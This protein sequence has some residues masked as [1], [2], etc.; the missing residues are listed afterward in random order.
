MKVSVLRIGII[1][2]LLLP[3]ASG[4]TT[5]IDDWYAISGNLN[6]TIASGETSSPNYEGI[7]NRNLNMIFSY[8]DPVTL[9]DGGKVELNFEITLEADVPEISFSA[10]RFGLFKSGDSRADAVFGESRVGRNTAVTEGWRGFLLIN[11]NEPIAT[12]PL[13]VYR[14]S[15]DTASNYVSTNDTDLTR[16]LPQ[17][18][19]SYSLVF[20]SG[21][22]R[23]FSLVFERVGDDLVISGLHDS[24]SFGGTLFGAF[25]GNYGDI[26]DAFGFYAS[27]GDAVVNGI[28]FSNA[29]ITLEG[30]DQP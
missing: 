25:G 6:A 21:Q 23:D 22:P 18:S 14:R 26:F 3:S 24:G 10:L 30:K 1:L 19:G 29:T 7:S 11:P 5:P 20:Q 28:R 4:E 13:T 9:L 15:A 2:A 8:F 16:G 12:N 17:R 27:E